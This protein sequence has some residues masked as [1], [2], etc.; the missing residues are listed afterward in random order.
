MRALTRAQPQDPG[1]WNNLGFLLREEGSRAAGD[2][3]VGGKGASEEATRL[4]RDSWAAYLE[5]VRLAPD[6]A[7]IVNDAALIQVYHLRDELDRAETMLR[8]A[9][10]IGE[11]QLAEMG[12]DPPEAR[13]FP[14]A[15]AVGDAWQNLAY[16]YYHV[17]P[18]PSRVKECVE[19]S[20][21]TRTDAREGL[22]AYVDA[23]EGRRAP[24]PERPQGAAPPR[25]APTERGQIAWQRSFDDARALAAAEHRP[26]FVFHRGDG[27]G[28]RAEYLDALLARPAF[29]EA[30]SVAACAV[31]DRARH[32]AVDRD[33]AGRRVPCPHYGVVTCGEHQR[34]CEQLAAAWAA[35]RRPDEGDAPADGLLLFRADGT[36]A[37][38]GGRGGLGGGF[39]EAAQ[40]EAP[41]ASPDLAPLLADLIWNEGPAQDAAAVALV[42]RPDRAARDA[43]EALLGLAPR[44]ALPLGA[45]GAIAGHEL[46][47]PT[48]A[49]AALV[50]AL[51]ARGDAASLE[52][53]TACA[54]PHSDP[55]A[56]AL[57]VVRVGD[58][59]DVARLKRLREWSDDARVR[60]RAEEALRSPARADR[61]EIA[62]WLEL[63]A[64][65]ER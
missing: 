41:V 48:S 26:L 52:A 6:D 49:V 61:D 7:R 36:R 50:A 27:L 13:R 44:D 22:R 32:G 28:V 10:R 42:A 18:D 60:A 51:A 37:P 24:I 34:A 47:V 14:V 64:A 35:L 1:A 23:V 12:P 54:G 46:V 38:I 21:A 9:I 5:A 19:N 56:C 11:A 33:A 16:L 59:L 63:I 29:A 2:A 55:V 15:Q 17:R 25:E 4:F 40:G 30:A 31:A 8:D 3:T 20:I 39:A 45:A 58:R 53:L 57:V 43:V 65:A 62:S